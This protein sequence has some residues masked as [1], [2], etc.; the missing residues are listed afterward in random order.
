MDGRRIGRALRAIRQELGWT[1]D[2]LA[3]RSGV[4]QSRISSAELGAI[5]AFTIRT[6][7]RVAG[8]LGATFWGQIRW[9]GG[10]IDRLT[11]QDHA[12]LVEGVISVLTQ[13]G[14]VIVPEYTFNRYGERGSVDVVG[15][16]ARSRTLLIVEVK[17]RLTD[18]QET[19]ATFGRK[20]RI[21]PRE[22]AGTHEWHALT[23]GR[24]LVIADTSGN[25]AAVSRHAATFDAVLPCR[26]RDVRR[27]LARPEGGLAGIW[28]VPITRT[29]GGKRVIRVRHAPSRA[30]TRTRR[31]R[32]PRNRSRSGTNPAIEPRYHPRGG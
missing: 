11:D 6:L 4:S 1:Q 22:L 10:D 7:E 31:A 8:T 24:V 30:T 29:A 14:W 32:D 15:W 19:L 23:T 18:L 12:A 27:W 21:A 25:R 5:D 26:S 17:S 28:F 3:R 9:R 13:T 16:H 20:L 2:E